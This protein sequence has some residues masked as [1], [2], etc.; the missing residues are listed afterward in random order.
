MAIGLQKT[1]Q[2][3]QE[4]RLQPALTA[5]GRFTKSYNIPGM[6][7]PNS[8]PTGLNV[9]LQTSMRAN[10]TCLWQLLVTLPR[11]KSQDR[12]AVQEPNEQCTPVPSKNQFHPS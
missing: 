8:G 4:Q 11:T 2:S 6:V 5:Y 7:F 12:H 1:W 9:Q 10:S 3:A